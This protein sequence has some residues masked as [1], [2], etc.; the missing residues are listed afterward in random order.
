LFVQ[1]LR[2]LESEDTGFSRTRILML[3]LDPIASG[4]KQSAIPAMSLE[5]MD[6][7]RRLPGVQSATFSENGIFS[8]TESGESV[9][10]PGYTFK[11]DD[12]RGIDNDHIGPD[13]FG[14]IG[15]HML[16]GRD[17]DRR[18]GPAAPKVAIINEAMARHYFGG[19]NPIG[20]QFTMDNHNTTL[21]I[22]GV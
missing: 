5:L 17:M 20:R 15:G 10:I 9:K 6:R 11:S 7:L 12:E 18:D 13:Y 2:N 3:E 8:G 1:T 21:Q 19:Q 4:Y 16:L 14:T 22:V